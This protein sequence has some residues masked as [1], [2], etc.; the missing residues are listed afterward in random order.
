M[1][2]ERGDAKVL[3]FELA[4]LTDPADTSED[5]ET[6]TL[7]AATEERSVAG[8]APY[9]SPEQAEGRKVDARS[10]IFSFGSVLCEMLTG[11]RAFTGKTRMATMAAVLNSEPVPIAK[12]VPDMPREV[13]R[14]RHTVSAQGSE[15]PQPEH[16][17]DPRSAAGS[18]G[19][20]RIRFARFR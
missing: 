13:E 19:G 7:R 5:D 6:R 15:S 2:T 12:L 1:I 16:G 9:M 11:K 3:D 14:L 17:R 4:K 20:V 10:D 18:E 8:S